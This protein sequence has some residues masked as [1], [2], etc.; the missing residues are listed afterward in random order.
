MLLVNMLLRVNVICYASIFYN[1]SLFKKIEYA[2]AFFI[3]QYLNLDK[4]NEI[5]IF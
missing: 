2:N 4:L 3:I 5:R 1:L